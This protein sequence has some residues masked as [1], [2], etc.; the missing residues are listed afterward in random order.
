M[1]MIKFYGTIRC[2]IVWKDAFGDSPEEFGNVIECLDPN[3]TAKIGVFCQK[4]GVEDLFNLLVRVRWYLVAV[5]THHHRADGRRFCTNA[6][7]WCWPLFQSGKRKHAGGKEA[8][9][10]RFSSLY[11]IYGRLVGQIRHI[12]AHAVHSHFFTLVNCVNE[13]AET[14]CLYGHTNW[15][16][17]CRQNEIWTV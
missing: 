1:C 12:P 3:L 8:S 11:E 15:W 9:T 6:K 5:T 14:H 4:N 2:W 10:S 17:S 16:N 13:Y 7:T